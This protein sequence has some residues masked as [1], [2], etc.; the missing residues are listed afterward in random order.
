MEIIEG[1]SGALIKGGKVLVIRR[2]MADDDLPGYYELPGGKIEPE[3]TKEQAVVREL[4]EELSLRVE[5][6]KP[7]YEFSYQP[8][9]N[10]KC[11]DYEYLAVLADGE[12]IDNL[13]LSSE[14][15]DHRWVNMEELD[16]ITP[17][18][19]EMMNSVKLALKEK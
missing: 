9:P 1:V 17:M 3:E 12:S 16:K 10:T 19:S 18:S 6:I 14:H 13:R 4:Q 15:D 5:V 11:T 8:G 7:Y 2:S